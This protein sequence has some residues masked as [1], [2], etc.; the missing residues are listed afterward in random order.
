MVR[1]C[2]KHYTG[3]VSLKAIS[4]LYIYT[5]SSSSIVYTDAFSS[6]MIDGLLFATE[7]Y[8]PQ[9]YINSPSKTAK[10]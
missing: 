4:C 7:L 6:Y 9:G 8:E 5:Y 3:S 2:L 10:A 1:R